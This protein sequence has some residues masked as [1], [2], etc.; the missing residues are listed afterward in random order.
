MVADHK[1]RGEKVLMTLTTLT[2]L[3]PYDLASAALVTYNNQDNGLAFKGKT[4]DHC[5]ASWI[6]SKRKLTTMLVKRT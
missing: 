4:K 2:A 3:K 6:T 5:F 1:A